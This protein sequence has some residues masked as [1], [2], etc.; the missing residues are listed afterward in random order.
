MALNSV[1]NYLKE[2]NVRLRYEWQ[3]FQRIDNDSEEMLKRFMNKDHVRVY[4]GCRNK[5]T[6]KQ[7]M[8]QLQSEFD[9]ILQSYKLKN[10]E[11]HEPFEYTI[12]TAE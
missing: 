9:K 3:T 5:V 1:R 8:Q 11:K 6:E 7:M 2:R 10:L 12:N 4:H